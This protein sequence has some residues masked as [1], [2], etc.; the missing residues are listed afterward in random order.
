M[1]AFLKKYRG[2][3]IYILTVLLSILYIVFGSKI[4]SRNFYF[5][6]FQRLNILQ[7]F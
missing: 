5:A 1:I 3:V 7:R 6:T 4:A 2:A